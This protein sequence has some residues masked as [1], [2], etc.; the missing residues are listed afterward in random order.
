MPQGANPV[1]SE[2]VRDAVLITVFLRHDQTNNL[3]AIQTRLKEAD[4]WERFP[5]E[6]VRVVSWTVAMGFGQIVTL[7]VPPPL[8]PLVNLELERS[9]WG[10]FR[11]ECYPTY[12]FLPVRER[13]RER[14]RNGGK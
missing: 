10:V 3:D 8:L 4:W 1:T 7:E 12:D 6:G 2:N 11:T 9:A 13:I 5:P 14:V